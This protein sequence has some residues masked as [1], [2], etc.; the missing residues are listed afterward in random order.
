MHDLGAKEAG[1]GN[2]PDN[3]S[4][5]H[6]KAKQLSLKQ[7]VQY[8]KNILGGAANRDEAF[9]IYSLFMRGPAGEAIPLY[10]AV[11]GKLKGKV[12]GKVRRMFQGDP[13]L[14]QDIEMLLVQ[15]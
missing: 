2:A 3:P 12:D 4:L 10:E 14:L 15:G 5:S 13:D 9:A 11:Q 6:S 8:L 7:R 1:K